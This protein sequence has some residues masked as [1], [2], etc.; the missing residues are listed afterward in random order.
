MDKNVG[1]N[2]SI[3]TAYK[4]YFPLQINLNDMKDHIINRTFELEENYLR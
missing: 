4:T 2:F 3:R 1:L